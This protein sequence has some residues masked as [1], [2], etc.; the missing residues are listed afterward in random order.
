MAFTAPDANGIITQT[1]RDLD[2]SGLAGNSGVT[3]TTDAGLTFYDFGTNRLI[4]TGTIFHDPEKDVV[5]FRHIST[6]S[7]VSTPVLA[8]SNPANN[9]K[10]VESYARDAEGRIVVTATGHGYLEGD[11]VR[12]R[13]VTGSNLEQQRVRIAEATADTFTI[14]QSDYFELPDS[15]Q[16]NSIQ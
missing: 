11:G 16:V 14:D 2:Y 3:I 7:T 15:T 1:G 6:D 8:I 13:L 4:V 12:F 5:I 9:W 10:T